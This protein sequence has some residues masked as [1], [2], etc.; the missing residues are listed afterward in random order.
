MSTTHAFH[1]YNQK[2]LYIVQGHDLFFV[3]DEE[4]NRVGYNPV[5]CG[6]C[7]IGDIELSNLLVQD[8]DGWLDY[9]LRLAGYVDHR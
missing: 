8:Y 1:D 4:L 9:N 3:P 5:Q 6:L 2:G 7:P